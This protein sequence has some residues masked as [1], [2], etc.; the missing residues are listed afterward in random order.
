MDLAKAEDLEGEVFPPGRHVLA[1]QDRTG[2]TKIIWS[3]DNA[4]EVG[5]ARR[6]FD[7]LR[8]KGFDIFRV[9]GKEGDKAEIMTAFDPEAERMIAAP[10]MRGG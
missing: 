8:G 6:T 10:R 1:I 4:D 9:R 5:N 3:R 7:E 2:D